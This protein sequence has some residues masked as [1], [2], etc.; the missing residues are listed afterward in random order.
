MPKIDHTPELDLLDNWLGDAPTAEISDVDIAQR[1][2]ASRLATPYMDTHS[3]HLN[4][5]QA[6]F[7]E[8]VAGL[9][10][11]CLNT[12]RVKGKATRLATNDG[13]LTAIFDQYEEIF[14]EHLKPLDQEERRKL[15]ENVLNVLQSE[16]P[17]AS[18]ERLARGISIAVGLQFEKTFEAHSRRVIADLAPDDL[19]DLGEQPSGLKTD[20]AILSHRSKLRLASFLV[21]TVTSFYGISEWIAII[22]AEL[23]I[24]SA[25]LTVWTERLVAPPLAL[26]ASLTILAFKKR[27][28]MVGARNNL[29][30]IKSY[31]LVLKERKAVTLLVTFALMPVDALTN[32]EGMVKKVF[33]GSDTTDQ[34]GDG[35][36]QI[37][38]CKALYDKAINGKETPVAFKDTCKVKDE[39]GAKGQD[40]T[41][42]VKEQAIV[43]AMEALIDEAS[44]SYSAQE[45]LGPRFFGLAA[46]YFRNSAHF[47]SSQIGFT[48]SGTSR[49]ANSMGDP[50]SY[51]PPEHDVQHPS[52]TWMIAQLA[53]D[54]WCVY[55]KTAMD[56][57]GGLRLAWILGEGTQTPEALLKQLAS[58]DDGSYQVAWRDYQD[59]FVQP[60]E[61]G[62]IPEL[63]SYSQRLDRI[64]MTAITAINAQLDEQ[65]TSVD[66]VTGKWNSSTPIVE[67]NEDATKVQKAFD[68]I[69]QER[70]AQLPVLGNATTVL[71]RQYSN[72][73]TALVNDVCEAQNREAQRRGARAGKCQEVA[74]PEAKL[75]LPHIPL[76]QVDFT[77]PGQD[78][79][80]AEKLANDISRRPEDLPK[81]TITV[82]AGALFGVMDWLFFS[83]VVRAYQK[84]RDAISKRSFA[85][86]EHLR[87]LFETLRIHLQSG[88]YAALYSPLDKNTL[89]PDDII[90]ER[91]KKALVG[92]ADEHRISTHDR[93][94]IMGMFEA[95]QRKLQGK[96]RPNFGLKEEFSLGLGL[97]LREET[98]IMYAYRRLLH[99]IQA[100]TQN[101]EALHEHL[102]RLNVDGAEFRLPELLTHLLRKNPNGTGEKFSELYHNTV[103]SAMHTL[104]VDEDNVKLYKDRALVLLQELGQL[105]SGLSLTDPDWIL[106]FMDLATRVR[107]LLTEIPNTLGDK[108][109]AKKLENQFYA[110]AS[111]LDSEEKKAEKAEAGKV[112]EV[113]TL[114][115]GAAEEV[116]AKY[117]KPLLSALALKLVGFRTPPAEGVINA[118]AHAQE[119][120]NRLNGLTTWEQDLTALEVGAGSLVV[121]KEALLAEGRSCRTKLIQMA[122]A[123]IEPKYLKQLERNRFNTFLKWCNTKHILPEDGTV[124]F[125][126]PP[127][128]KQFLIDFV[129]FYKEFFDGVEGAPALDPITS[130]EINFKVFQAAAEYFATQL[131]ENSQNFGFTDLGY[132]QRYDPAYSL[133]RGVNA[134]SQKLGQNFSIIVDPLP[135]A[136][137]IKDQYRK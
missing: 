31:G 43:T 37:S 67:Y 75:E 11:P 110:F 68:A 32:I 49:C 78:R 133:A 94:M 24:K 71:N 66:N 118:A 21:G 86:K 69:Q 53:E 70:D 137:Q 108:D 8:K 29:G 129:K 113:E 100:Y 77:D 63:T 84:D 99:G 135:V 95:F 18:A 59:H 19:R 35:L 92:L 10:Q 65:Y 36:Q 50:I 58:D 40:T 13:L 42:S 52:H 119:I 76:V 62:A 28:E 93:G 44:G 34:I 121:T 80:W 17:H 109:V 54:K 81:A 73:N 85:V 96:E 9:I 33:G 6:F 74:I 82:L 83:A 38:D 127:D 98:P 64:W 72:Y 30:F 130:A 26:M 1:L 90:L 104:P 112:G 5:R 16:P 51:V 4:K 91:L 3:G 14:P 126:T 88:P 97:Y 131:R 23:G 61:A 7:E 2:E 55:D 114:E 47:S 79:N 107:E 15:S 25:L 105:K 122:E 111:S 20:S 89:I 125:K 124:Q 120:Q 116:E 102:I 48:E 39:S 57:S 103:S 128:A 117:Y 115:R 101:P 60:T 123:S 41:G 136:K 87:E 134:A 106:A 132:I 46:A 27:V 22:G 12:D 45:G 56:T